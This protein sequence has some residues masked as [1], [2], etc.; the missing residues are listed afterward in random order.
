MLCPQQ[1][2]RDCLGVVNRLVDHKL[3][4]GT[5]RSNAQQ[6]A[7][8]IWKSMYPAEPF[9]LNLE[10]PPATVPEYSS[11]IVYD[12]EAA[13]ARQSQ[14]YY[15]VSLPHYRDKEF[16]KTGL[17]RYEYHLKLKKIHPEA[18]LVPCYDIDLIWH[19]HQ[20]HPLA[21]KND[22]IALLGHV[23]NHDDTTT[24][25]DPG[26]RLAN[27]D[28]A[29]RNLWNQYGLH[30]GVDGAMYRGECPPPRPPVP[31]GTYHSLAAKR[32]DISLLSV[33]VDNLD[34]VKKFKVKLYVDGLPSVFQGTT[35][36]ASA[37]FS[38][39]T[40]PL[41]N[42]TFR[43][44]TSRN[45]RVKIKRSGMFSSGKV[46][47]DH[48]FDFI[49][50][51]TNH[52]VTSSSGSEPLT[53]SFDFQE[54]VKIQFTTRIVQRATVLKYIFKVNPQQQFTEIQ[55]PSL[56]VSTPKLFLSP[57]AL[58]TPT[59]PCEMSI[60]Q[61]VDNLQREAFSCRVVHAAQ[62]KFSS[63][64]VINIYGQVIASS[65]LID[66]EVLRKE[67]NWMMPKYVHWKY[68]KARE[69]C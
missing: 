42:F 35:K 40:K 29:T 8:K 52:L 6:K 47:V 57:T 68:P 2:E 27:A 31:G 64:E 7:L 60:H 25:R 55:H 39:D 9:N 12:I 21:Y 46:L 67:Y 66:R 4:S 45:L 56:L 43:T 33:Q 62:I 61:V 26:S 34:P 24:D 15:Q 10:N 30:F 3:M 54:G 48:A 20:A 1:Y 23:F 53:H 44:D 22:T 38:K 41:C 14:F 19:A 11:K 13:A 50:Y 51:V 58:A 17:K 49:N 59:V 32:Y 65:H 69:P 37:R 16:L 18:F 28:Q 63:V 36:G 5:N